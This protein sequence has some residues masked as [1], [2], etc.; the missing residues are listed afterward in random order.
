[1]KFCSSSEKQTGKL[2]FCFTAY[3]KQEAAYV[4]SQYNYYVV[5]FMIQFKTLH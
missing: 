1:M 2:C 5:N 4:F 3:F